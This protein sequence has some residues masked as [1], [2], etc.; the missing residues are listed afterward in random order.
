MITDFAPVIDIFYTGTYT[1]TRSATASYTSDGRLQP[2]STSTF[3]IR[4]SVQP[5]PA[6]VLDDTQPAGLE[7]SA[8]FAVFT[9]TELRTTDSGQMP[10]SVSIGGRDFQVSTVV[11]WATLGGYW[12]YLVHEI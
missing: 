1:V 11:D 5:A 10:D 6:R 3:T 9:T 4:A 12:Q 2:A 8:S 7:S